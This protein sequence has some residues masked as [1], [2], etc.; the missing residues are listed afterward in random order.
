MGQP[1][2]C[3]SCSEL[4]RS[5]TS[6]SATGELGEPSSTPLHSQTHILSD[7]EAVVDLRNECNP[8]DDKSLADF[9][10]KVV[11]RNMELEEEVF[12]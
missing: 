7:C 2:S 6:R 12:N 8:E 1:L 10:R 4:N 3:P 9:F 5:L 11:A